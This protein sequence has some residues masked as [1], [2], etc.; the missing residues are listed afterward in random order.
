MSGTYLF[1]EAIDF[2][3]AVKSYFGSDAAYAELQS[4]LAKQP[5]KGAVMPGASPLR[6]LRWGE[7]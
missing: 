5:E 6:K 3:S 4:E 7:E 2:T 1:I